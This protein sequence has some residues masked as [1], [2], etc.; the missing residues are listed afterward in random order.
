MRARSV[1]GPLVLIVIGIV[2]LLINL[3]FAPAAAIRA[4]FAQWW[5]LILVIAGVWLLL[6]PRREHR[7]KSDET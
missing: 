2:F 1:V 7:H 6:R 4:L 3:G 5:P